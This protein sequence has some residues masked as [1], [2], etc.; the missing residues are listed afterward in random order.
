MFLSCSFAVKDPQDSAGHNAPA[1]SANQVA[2]TARDSPL[3]RDSPSNRQSLA[4]DNA[5][6]PAELAPVEL[7][8]CKTRDK[9]LA[10]DQVL[11]TS[12]HARGPSESDSDDDAV[13]FGR[14]VR[15]KVKNQ[16]SE[17][18]LQSTADKS[19]ERGQRTSG[20]S[21]KHNPKNTKK[22]RGK[23]KAGRESTKKNDDDGEKRNED[24]AGMFVQ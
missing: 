7:A 3:A 16:K 20:V 1:P 15:N 22:P 11:A 23:K 24:E 9:A 2:T 14:S 13:V 4:H 10:R 8:R 21:E 19:V 12:A 5:L 6:A 17:N 18:T